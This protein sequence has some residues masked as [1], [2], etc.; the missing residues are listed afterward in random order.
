M[1]ITYTDPFGPPWRFHW[2]RMV[3]TWRGGIVQAIW[4]EWLLATLASALVMWIWLASFES[5]NN[6][7]EWQAR[8]EILSYALGFV[9]T[10]FQ[11]ALGLMLGFYTGT[12]YSRWWRVR[13]LENEVI[14]AIKDTSIHVSALVYDSTR[15]GNNPAIPP[16]D[17]LLPSPTAVVDEKVTT[18]VVEV[19]GDKFTQDRNPIQNNGGKH[20]RTTLPNNRRKN[21]PISNES[22]A[23]KATDTTSANSTN[24]HSNGERKSTA[25]GLSAAEV[26]SAMLRWVNLSHALAIGV[27]YERQPNAFSDLDALVEM[28]L[29]ADT[30]YQFMTNYTGDAA[31][32]FDVPFVWF[33]D[34]LGEVIRL[35]RFDMPMPAVAMLSNN[36]ARV[37]GSLQNIYMYRT[38]PVP[39]AYR[40]LVNLTV[41]FYMVVLLI[42]EGLSA[43]NFAAE[44]RNGFDFYRTVF[45]MIMPF[46]F[47]YFLFV[48]WLTLADAL[49]NPFRHWADE[50]EWEN[51]VRTTYVAS[52]ALI[53]ESP[54]SCSTLGSSLKVAEERI[55]Q[56]REATLAAWESNHLTACERIK[57]PGKAQTP[58][59]HS[60]RDLSD[61]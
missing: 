54:K 28:G 39:L 17:L 3:W 33:M 8:T 50:F 21:K 38:E 36:V 57:Q 43:L 34:L 24:D 16:L 14:N 47:E 11:A 42:N 13:N 49:G 31:Q 22:E 26:R 27:F 30:E 37:R 58:K 48:G 55:K 46:G 7:S 44:E 59:V 61:F 45:W 56:K 53:D 23:S 12:L 10:R 51:F 25:E 4:V 18:D 2:Q 20:K 29:L 1:T 19:T 5:Y 15:K 40:Q 35:E 9:T 32:A 6:I 60:R 41:R 52:F